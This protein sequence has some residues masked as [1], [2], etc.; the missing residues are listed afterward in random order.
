GASVVLYRSEELRK[1]QIFAYSGWPGGL[2]GSP[3]MAGSR[4]GGTIAAAWAAMRVLGEDG[5]TDIASQLM[6][7]RA[8]VLDAVRNIP[9][10]QVVGEPHM[11]IFALMS[12]DPKFD[13]LVLADIL[14][15]KGWKIERQ[16]LPISIHFTLMPHHLNVLDGFIADLKA[17]AEDV[18]ANPGQSAGGTAAMYGMMAKIPDKGIIDD[19]IVEFFS[20]MYKN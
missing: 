6:N 16:Q 19:F 3:S 15:N 13:I 11:T 9:S 10:L 18:K 14:E 7:A 17:A 5:Y 12:A 4:P 1:Y 20:E 2:F 8:K